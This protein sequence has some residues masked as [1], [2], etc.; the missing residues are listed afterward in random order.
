MELDTLIIVTYFSFVGKNK[1]YL[2]NFQIFIDKNTN[3]MCNSSK[4]ALFIVTF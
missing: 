4:I 3:N 2:S 1:D